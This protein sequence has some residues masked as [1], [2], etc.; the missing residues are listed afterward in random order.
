MFL[1]R[2]NID[3][4]PS[5]HFGKLNVDAAHHDLR[6]I[7]ASNMMIDRLAMQASVVIGAL[8]VRFVVNW[9]LLGF[10]LMQHTPITALVPPRRE[11]F[12]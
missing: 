3:G 7:A 4:H 6:D 2:S 12:H 8:T 5:L 11:K 9:L 10:G 1:C